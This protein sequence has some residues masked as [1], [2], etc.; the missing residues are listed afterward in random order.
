M[1]LLADICPTCGHRKPRSK[2]QNSRYWALLTKASEKLGHSKDVW[3]VFL[4]D[5]FLPMRIV[6]ICGQ[7]K[8]IRTSTHNLP[9]HPD[10][11]RPNDPSWETYTLQVEAFLSEHGVYLEH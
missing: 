11:N 7:E 8:L 10:I 2:P 6:L 3:H 5:K 4:V 1:S 9:M